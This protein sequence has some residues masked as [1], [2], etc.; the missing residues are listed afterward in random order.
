[1]EMRKENHAD[2]MEM[3]KENR[4]DLSEMQKE[5][6]ANPKIPSQRKKESLI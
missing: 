2:P 1:M 5:A 4:T 3:R 6:A